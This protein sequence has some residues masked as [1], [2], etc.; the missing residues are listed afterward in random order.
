MVVGVGVGVAAAGR[1]PAADA[2]FV[3]GSVG[4]G[5]GD[6]VRPA[7]AAEEAVAALTGMAPITDASCSVVRKRARTAG[8]ARRK[9][10]GLS[11]ANRRQGR[12]F[13]R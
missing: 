8:E 5:G 13:L 12:N 6:W 3:A 2:G 10:V 7:V 4:V 11:L 9:E 1:A